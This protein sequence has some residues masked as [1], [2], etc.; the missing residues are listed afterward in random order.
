[1]NKR[2]KVSRM[3]ERHKSGGFRRRI[4]WYVVI[5]AVV[6]L[7]LGI[8][9][10]LSYHLRGPISLMFLVPMT[11]FAFV[12]LRQNGIEL[13]SLPTAILAGTF[14]M[15]LMIVA[16]GET[17]HKIGNMIQSDPHKESGS[18]PAGN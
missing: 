14:F 6:Q 10:W 18:G 11:N 1:M 13:A 16:I 5:A 4:C 12:W 7:V 8:L 9:F 3:N 15:F 2:M 17:Y